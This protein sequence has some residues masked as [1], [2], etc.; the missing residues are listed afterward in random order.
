[1]PDDK[2]SAEQIEWALD[3]IQSIGGTIVNV[4]RYPPGSSIV[5]MAMERGY[6]NI[7]RL[8]EVV[9]SFTFGESEKQLLVNEER[10]ADKLQ[11]RAYVSRFVQTMVERNIRSLTFY[12]G[13]TDQELVN[14]SSLLG[15]SPEEL[16]K[17]GA[18]A[19]LLKEK[20][21]KHIGVDEKIFVALSKDQVVADAADLERLSNDTAQRPD[22]S[23]EGVFLRYLTAKLA[24]S[25]ADLPKE[26]LDELKKKIQY[27]RILESRDI[28]FAKLGPALAEALERLTHESAESRPAA[29][30]P[31][32][33]PAA[34][35][36]SALSPDLARSMAGQ[37]QTMR[38]DALDLSRDER[39]E[40]LV[41]TF[42]GV[43]RSILEF[44]RP[45]VRERLVSDF[46][47]IITNFKAVTLSH[48]LSAELSANEQT[49]GDLK[50]QIVSQL[51]EPKQAAVLDAFVRRC[52]RMVDGLAPGDFDYDPEELARTER[53]LQRM[54][55]ANASSASPALGERARRAVAIS[56]SLRK[57]APDAERLLILKTRRLFG[58]DAASLLAERTL[59][60][61]PDLV[62]RLLDLK[63]PDAAK[64]VLE[65]LFE[66]ASSD[67]AELR[68]QTAGA[69]VRIGQVLL[70]A[71]TYALHAPLYALLLRGYRRE[72][73]QRVYAAYLAAVVAD[74]GRLVESARFP[75]L[76]QVFNGIESLRAEEQDPVKRK[77]LEMAE[78]KILGQE[79][80]LEQLRDRFVDA[81]EKVAELAQQVLASIPADRVAP[82]MFALLQTSE[83]MRA[84]K[85]ALAMLTRLGAEAAPLTREYLS[86]PSLPWYFI[87]NLVTLAGDLKDASAET[88]IAKHLRHEHP[89][90]RKACLAALMRLGTAFAGDALAAELPN[91]D[92]A[93]QRLVINHL[94]SVKSRAGLDFIRTTLDPTLVERD[95][96]LALD[97][98]AALGRAGD[99]EAAPLLKKLLRPGGI[100]GLF[101]GK[102]NER[103]AAAVLRALGEIGGDEAKAVLSKYVRDPDA[104]VAKTA[105]QALKKLG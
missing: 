104:T 79:G 65:R 101:K 66:N 57:E 20:G 68:L 75:L 58:R 8:F 6:Q 70:D 31:E 25:E 88:A 14:F 103:I 74:V 55:S 60:Y 91:L 21:V 27:D 2:L 24:E 51:A 92:A 47:K 82:M 22:G 105:Q 37:E 99:A 16:R 42:Q 83:D 34:T 23:E 93:N 80:F 26:K 84:R 98:I 95:E 61:L 52:H 30:A 81:D 15:H 40:R 4:K 43:A 5:K 17:M 44:K 78:G 102:A 76:V 86:A 10:L 46:L 36:V 62:V 77:F 18:V 73:D 59:P 54:T 11:G 69:L 97:L 33:P 9:E 53:L 72:N 100:A 50:T 38:A 94:A 35:I 39:G 96:P 28:D 3:A 90:V 67:D 48:L 41:K 56:A 45:E 87:R 12:R 63:R 7:Q 1:M 29:P 13:L 64:R 71:K 32:P 19:D 49:D 85:R 89:Q